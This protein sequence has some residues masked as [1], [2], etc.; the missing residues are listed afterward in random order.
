LKKPGITNIVETKP[1][2]RKYSILGGGDIAFPGLLTASVYF[3]HGLAP[4]IIMAAASAVGLGG[5]Y[6]IQSIFLK[7]KPMPALPPIAVCVLIGL[8]IIQL[9]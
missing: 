7:G 2:D 4:G 8:I 5:A 9:T 3:A 1:A 6:M